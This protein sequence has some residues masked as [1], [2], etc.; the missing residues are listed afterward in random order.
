LSRSRDAANGLQRAQGKKKRETSG[1]Q[2]STIADKKKGRPK[3]FDEHGGTRL[4]K[5]KWNRRRAPGSLLKIGNRSDEKG[6]EEARK[7]GW[8]QN[9]GTVSP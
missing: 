8:T 9:T 4:T 5:N 6:N 3:S 7:K 1:Q 2:H